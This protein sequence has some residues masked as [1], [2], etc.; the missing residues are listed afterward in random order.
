MDW[1]TSCDGGRPVG[2]CS[3]SPRRAL[4]RAR[5][6]AFAR[7]HDGGGLFWSWIATLQPEATRRRVRGVGA[8]LGEAEDGGDCPVAAGDEAVREGR[9]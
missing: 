9:S 3:H 6:R 2:S 5:H 8:A 7:C 4:P 1:R